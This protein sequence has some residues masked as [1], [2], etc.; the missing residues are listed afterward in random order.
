MS[1]E[2]KIPRGVLLA[3]KVVEYLADLLAAGNRKGEAKSKLRELLHV[4][5]FKG[6]IGPHDFEDCRNAA[7]DLNQRLV[8]IDRREE[9]SNLIAAT[10]AILADEDVS[11]I[12]RLKAIQTLSDLQGLG[13]KYKVTQSKED[14]VDSI[15]KAVAEIDG[16]DN[17]VSE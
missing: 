14:M 17:N 4:A 10:K 15:R 16:P 1:D 11:G 6:S 12:T 7:R 8:D 3:D 13:A 2:T 9:L 5:G